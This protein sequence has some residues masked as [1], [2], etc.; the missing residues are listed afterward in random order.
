MLHSELWV[1]NYKR[2]RTT[3]L[4]ENSIATSATASSANDND[5]VIRASSASRE[6]TYSHVRK[7]VLL[8][9]LLHPPP[10]IILPFVSG[11][12][13]QRCIINRD[14]FLNHGRGVKPKCSCF[15]VACASSGLIWHN[16]FS[17]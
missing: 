8:K 2:L 16:S 1:A 7:T 12:W 15:F 14:S 4:G 17:V 6:L 9:L 11:I 10:F 13:T 5:T 3:N